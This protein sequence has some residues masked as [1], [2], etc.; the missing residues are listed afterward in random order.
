MK[1]QGNEAP[2]D[3]VY[4]VPTGYWRTYEQLTRHD[5]PTISRWVAEGCPTYAEAREI[6]IFGNHRGRSV[7]T[8][9]VGAVYQQY[10]IVISKFGNSYRLGMPQDKEQYARLFDL[11]AAQG[12]LF[13]VTQG[14]Q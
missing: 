4:L 13:R 8:A 5:P 11:A 14:E 10:G 9:A 3:N 6:Y 1:K 12:I 2:S 7:G